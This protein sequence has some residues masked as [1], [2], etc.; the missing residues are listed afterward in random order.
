MISTAWERQIYNFIVEYQKQNGVM[1]S[2]HKIAE[3]MKISMPITRY[4]LERLQAC[5]AV[6]W[7]PNRPYTLHVIAPFE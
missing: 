1:P 6:D 2:T 7:I 3:T 4:Y 5:G